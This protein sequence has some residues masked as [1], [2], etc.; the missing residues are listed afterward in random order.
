MATRFELVLAGGPEPQ[1]RAAGEQAIALIHDLEARLSRFRATSE[2]GRSNALAAERP[3]RIDGGVFELLVR[4]RALWERTG[5][6]F[7]VTVGPLMQCWGL[8]GGGGRVPAAAELAAAR[9]RVGMHLLEL[10]P[11]RCTVRFARPGVA[12]DLGGIGKGYALEQAAEVLREA[13]VVSALL[14]GGT[15]S[16][17][18]VGGAPDGRG[19]RIAIPYPAGVGGETA[20]LGA[21]GGEPPVV[22]V[23]ELRDQALGVSAGHGKQFRAGDAWY[24]HV[25]D[26]RLGRPAE[27]AL[28]AAVV[29]DSGTEA[30]AL[31]TALLVLGAAGVPLL[32]GAASLVVARGAGAEAYRV[33]ASGIPTLAY[34]AAARPQPAHGA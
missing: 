14:H 13:G 8:A 30:D 32:P 10:D 34:P 16:V 28:L 3:V 22:A 9:D 24:G 20:G 21:D 7:D 15:S 33:A 4:A 1:L 29:S 19:W 18:A 6:A 12:I 26:P 31:A 23:V 5:G 27:A 25:L 11:A 17:Q 2:I